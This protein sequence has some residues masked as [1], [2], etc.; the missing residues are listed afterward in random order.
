M[1]K[2]S[3]KAAILK[4]LSRKCHLYCFIGLQMTKFKITWHN[5]KKKRAF[6][7]CFS[8]IFPLNKEEKWMKNRKS[9]HLKNPFEKKLPL[10]LSNYSFKHWA[11]AGAFEQKCTL[12]HFFWCISRFHVN[13]QNIILTSAV[14]GTKTDYIWHCA[15][16]FYISLF[17]HI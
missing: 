10:T 1:D 14:L 11:N 12:M 5:F 13:C 2:T 17:Y 15:E 8:S 6:L 16:S 9:S 4:T 3:E 7:A